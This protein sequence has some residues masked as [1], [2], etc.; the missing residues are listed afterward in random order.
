M[1]TS[2]TPQQPPLKLVDVYFT[3]NQDQLGQ[4]HPPLK[5]CQIPLLVDDCPTLILQF[6]QQQLFLHHT[7]NENSNIN[8]KST[9]NLCNSI[10][11]SNKKEYEAFL[12]KYKKCSSKNSLVDKC[13]ADEKNNYED[14]D[15]E[16]LEEEAAC[17]SCL[18]HEEEG[19][20]KEVTCTCFKTTISPHPRIVGTQNDLMSTLSKLVS[21]IGCKTSVERFYK[22]LVAA[23]NSRRLNLMNLDKNMRKKL[24]YGR[25]NNGGAGS[26]LDPFIIRS[27]GDLTLKRSILMDPQSVYKLFYLNW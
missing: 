18:Q 2:S 10:S 7:N 26:A 8:L 27:N 22:Q 1:S 6:N 11:N 14:E 17:E 24:S 3:K 25:S 20:E 12:S 16:E 19:P 23:N 13:K 9:C 4:Q 15:E 5:K 21:C